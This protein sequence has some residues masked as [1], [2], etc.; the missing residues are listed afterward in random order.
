MTTTRRSSRTTRVPLR[1]RR[2]RSP[3]RPLRRGG[4]AHRARP[5][6]AGQPDRLEVQR[7]GGQGRGIYGTPG[8]FG[9]TIIVSADDGKLTAL[10]RKTGTVKWVKQMRRPRVGEPCRR[11]QGVTARRRLPLRGLPRLRRVSNPDVDPPELWKVDLP[12][13]I[14]ATPAVWKGRV[15]IGHPGRLPS[16]S[17]GTRGSPPRR[18]TVATGDTA[19]ADTTYSSD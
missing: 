19:T 16:T 8:I 5:V 11:R 7:D 18:S 4:P 6:E 2:E 15:Y 9:N 10:D 1:R 3:R 14:E 17:S 12:G 13:C